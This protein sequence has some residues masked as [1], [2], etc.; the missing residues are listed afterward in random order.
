M[1]DVYWKAIVE[2]DTAFDG[3]VF[4]GVKT[5]GIFCRPSCRS[6]TPK[7]ENVVIFS[8]NSEPREDG[9]RPC[10]R[11]RPDLLNPSSAQDDLVNQAA[12]LLS[13][14]YSRD[15]K[16]NNLA[17]RLY[18]SRFYLQRVFKQ[19]LGLSPAEFLANRRID[20]AR[21]LLTTTELSITEVA[22]ETGFHNPAYFSTLFHKKTGVAPSKFRVLTKRNA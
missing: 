10:K 6:K 12:A 20:A 2:C 5:T 7:K 15:W 21:E 17:E 22:A 3:D 8:N 13:A 18:I 1:E 4:Y 19:R 9:F 14:S 11:C 16:L